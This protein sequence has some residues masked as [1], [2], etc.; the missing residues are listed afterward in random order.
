MATSG[1][2]KKTKNKSH[3]WHIILFFWSIIILF[4][5]IIGI[6]SPSDKQIEWGPGFAIFGIICNLLFVYAGWL[7][8]RSAK[9]LY[10]KNAVLLI[11]LCAV[12]I[13]FEIINIAFFNFQLYTNSIVEKIGEFLAILFL[14][15]VGTNTYQLE[16][17]I[18][19][20]EAKALKKWAWFG[21]LGAVIIY[22]IMV[23]AT[24]IVLFKKYGMGY[25]SLS[26]ETMVEEVRQF[27]FVPSI[28]LTI[29]FIISVG[30]LLWL[31]GT[32]LIQYFKKKKKK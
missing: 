12:S 23:V 24:T 13:I 26:K 14:V 10:R 7:V 18:Q 16:K 6:L 5:C 8:F 1:L 28:I 27:S 11:A 20:P 25:L 32:Q 4:F 31:Y 3:A 29:L 15:N 19:W 2:M 9:G 21:L 17:I 22:V 30:S